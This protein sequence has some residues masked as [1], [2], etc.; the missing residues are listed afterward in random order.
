MS[1]ERSQLRFGYWPDRFAPLNQPT[2]LTPAA[3]RL[4]AATI[5][6]LAKQGVTT[7]LSKVGR[8]HFS[9]V[10]ITSRDARRM[11]EVHGDLIEAFLNATTGRGG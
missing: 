8:V 10:K 4:A 1:R 6:N 5:E 9:S 3:R 7:A 11:I 2:E